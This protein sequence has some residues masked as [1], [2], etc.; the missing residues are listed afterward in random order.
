M[1]DRWLRNG[2][3]VEQIAL[4]WN[5]GNLGKCSSGV[6]KKGVKFDSCKYSRLVLQAH[7]NLL[8]KQ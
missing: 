2:L 6:N 1:I 8:E 3:T 7:Q 5:Q 4:M